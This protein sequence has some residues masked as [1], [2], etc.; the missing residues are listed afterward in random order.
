LPSSYD[1][2]GG[3]GRS[4]RLH[5]VILVAGLLLLLLLTGGSGDNADTGVKGGG[6]VGRGSHPTHEEEAGHHESGG[7][8]HEGG[9]G[10]G[11]GD[12]DEEL[13]DFMNSPE[14][15]RMSTTD[16]IM[17]V[18]AA[19][20]VAESE[21]AKLAKE[22]S[23]LMRKLDSSSEPEQEALD[24]STEE[25]LVGDMSEPFSYQSQA[26]RSSPSSDQCSNPV[27]FMNN[28]QCQRVAHHAEEDVPL[29]RVYVYDVP[30]KFTTDMTHK[31]KRCST[32]QYGTEVFFH[33]AL[34]GA[35]DILV[36]R[37]EDAD[38]FF[39]PIYGECFL[40]SWEMLRREN[41]A[42]SFELT[43]ALYA[44][45]VTLIRRQTWWNR[46][47]GRDHVFVFPGARGPTIFNEWQHQVGHSI[48]LTP[49]GDRKAN[50]FDTWKDIVIP[51]MEADERMYLAKHRQ[52]LVDN[53]PQRKWLAM[54]RGT[55][56]H[57]EGNAYSRGL[58]PR[59]KKIFA[60][61]SD[62]IYDTKKQD[63]NRDCYVQEMAESVFCMN[64]LG[65]TPWT[66][67]FYQAVMTRCIPIVIADDIEFPY[68]SEINYA[69][70][71]LKLPE[72][73]VNNIL[74]I[75][76]GM[77]EDERERRRREMDRL[78]L[79][80]TYQRPPRRGDAFYSTMRELGRKK[81]TMRNGVNRFWD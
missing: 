31:W 75:M 58:R 72:K 47:D 77:P 33:E 44:E 17:A 20:H 60:N 48:Y 71:T 42:K 8:E 11:G 16:R 5:T 32:D 29:P 19:L 41:R 76:R 38:F 64:P 73:D 27:I 25:D 68:E 65:W 52:H 80:F 62:V 28:P 37:P 45:L 59:L 57:R 51:G 78:W 56:D 23:K 6:A 30:T 49:E 67:R 4:R 81:R 12:H 35:R 70:F 24:P 36:T 63:C 1:D 9:G 10:G 21:V 53:P 34:T 55:I 26:T 74:V 14:F 61:V 13:D 43:N 69:S 18:D 2:G 50:Y 46:T 22:R 40:W 15:L 39:V 79:K 3:N 54:F 66:L 7:G